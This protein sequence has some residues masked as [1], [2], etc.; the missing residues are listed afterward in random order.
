MIHHPHY[1]TAPQ[2]CRCAIWYEI[3]PK[4]KPTW[5]LRI[6]LAWIE[7]LWFVGGGLK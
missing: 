5:R 1:D 6:W 4:M 7:V 3:T 2:I